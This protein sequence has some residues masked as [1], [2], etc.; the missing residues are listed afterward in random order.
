M[1]QLKYRTQ[2]KTLAEIPLRNYVGYVWY[3]NES[4]P[5]LLPEEI[6]KVDFFTSLE[7]PF[8]IEGLLWCESEQKSI[9]IRHTGKYFIYE[10]DLELIP[11]EYL[12]PKAY[13][14]HR[15]GDEVKNVRFKQLWL[16]EKDPLCE[17]MEVMTMKALIFTGFNS[18]TKT[19]FT[20]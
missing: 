18:S 13:L 4:K 19:W 10:Y 12:V 5:T 17:D 16:P 1:E 11:N 3:S 6:E 2:Y 15:L 20:L 9:M 14:P 7:N 8:I